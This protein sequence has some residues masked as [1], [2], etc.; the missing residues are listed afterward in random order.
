[1]T[2]TPAETPKTPIERWTGVRSGQASRPEPAKTALGLNQAVEPT[3]KESLEKIARELVGS[4]FYGTLMKQMHDSP[5]KSE[6]FSGGRG[7]QAFSPLYDQHMIQRMSGNSADRLVRP[8]VKRFEKAAA[9]AYEKQQIQKQ[10]HEQ[11]G[12]F[13]S[14]YRRA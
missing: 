5:F 2:V 4:T 14:T 9:A 7:E 3:P 10:K 11:G 12:D 6:I 8:I 1:M 13:V